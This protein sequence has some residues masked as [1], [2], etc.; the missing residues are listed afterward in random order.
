MRVTRRAGN[1]AAATVATKPTAKA[2]TSSFGTT[3]M[4]AGR[5]ADRADQNVFHHHQPEYGRPAIAERHHG[6]KIP[7][8]LE[9]AHADAVGDTQQNHDE[10][11]QPQHPELPVVEC[12][13]LLV[14]I[15]QFV[16]LLYFELLRIDLAREQPGDPLRIEGVRERHDQRIDAIGIQKL[17][18]RG[19]RNAYRPRVV[20]PGK[21]PECSDDFEVQRVQRAAGSAGQQRYLVAHP[22]LEGVG[23]ALADDDAVPVAIVERAP[24][25]DSNE[26]AQLAFAVRLDSLADDRVVRTAGV[27]ET[28]EADPR[29]DVDHARHAGDLPSQRIGIADHESV[30][31]PCALLEEP[32]RIDLEVPELRVNHRLAQL[33]EH[34]RDESSRQDEADDAEEDRAERH[35]RT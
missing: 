27:K 33:D 11:D 29:H 8:A 17:L 15:G 13:G 12:D 14:K 18:R 28:R 4:Y 9:C 23:H 34:V 25:I 1:T 21:A 31:R 20:I 2:S 32:P 35:A 10:D 22:D 5:A 19:Q 24:R 16:P 3:R 26:R 6:P 7:N 30:R